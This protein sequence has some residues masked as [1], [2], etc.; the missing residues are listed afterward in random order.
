M[1]LP[2][3][4]RFVALEE[5]I[6]AQLATLFPG[7]DI[8]ERVPFRVT[9]N[10]DLA[11]EEEEADDLLAAVEM[12][13]PARARID[14]MARTENNWYRTSLCIAVSYPPSL[15]SHLFKYFPLF[16]VHWLLNKLPTNDPEPAS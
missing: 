12:E 9:R 14:K 5:V 2:G 13:L 16:L 6:G 11:V 3:G 4:Q 15:L 8:V 10:A 7:M 1:D